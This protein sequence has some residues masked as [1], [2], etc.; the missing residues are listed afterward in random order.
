L[1]TLFDADLLEL[2]IQDNAE[3]ESRVARIGRGLLKRAVQNAE[4][5]IGAD[6]GGRPAAPAVRPAAKGFAPPAAT[7]FA[8]PAATGFAPPAATP[9]A[10]I[11]APS[12]TK[13]VA[14]PTSASGRYLSF[15][16][17]DV[18]HGF[19]NHRGEVCDALEIRP[20]P[21]TRK[22]LASYGLTA[23]CRPDGIDIL[24]TEGHFESAAESLAQIAA[25]WIR[26][27]G[28][29]AAALADFAGEQLFGLP[30]LFTVALTDRRFSSFT[31]LPADFAFGRP[32]L[33][34]SN[35]RAAD[36]VAG[37]VGEAKIV[38]EGAPRVTRPIRAVPIATATPQ[39]G[40]SKDEPPKVDASR[41]A[42]RDGPAGVER[43]QVRAS[44][45]DFALLD[46]YM[47][48]A[49]GVA[50]AASGAWD[51]MPVS[52]D[53]GAT[54]M[55]APCSYT[56]RFEARETRW[57]YIV[58]R[59]DGATPDG[60]EYE[61]VG[62]DDKEAGFALGGEGMLPDGRTAICLE[63]R[64]ALPILARPEKNLSLK[65]NRS[66]GRPRSAILVPRLPVAGADNFAPARWPA[67]GS[68]PA[69]RPRQ[70]WSNMYVFV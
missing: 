24:W 34:L 40:D 57:R 13:T 2:L 32:P 45:R 70:A 6:V 60:S 14:E 9:A 15:I 63:S 43:E 3:T 5:A 20:T 7:G 10:A 50:P 4:A 17:I 49:P 33:Q 61:V 31:A 47:V 29:P 41:P 59:R 54:R 22:R 38:I 11:A 35:R 58:A 53:P 69:D 27:S 25:L 12:S 42:A 56:L 30:L 44:S 67:G 28:R 62:P 16:R 36:A 64:D 18:R 52:L 65:R 23:R 68:A 46:L 48:R 21:E 19:F 8:P 1:P 37:E 39:P 26:K 66:D 55:L 51:G